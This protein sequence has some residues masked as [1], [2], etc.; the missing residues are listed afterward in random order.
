[1]IDTVKA[2]LWGAIGIRRRSAHDEAKI[3]PVH[4]AIL[5]VV[6]AVLFVL[7]LVTIVRIVTS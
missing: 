3:N 5:G 1:M 7:T 2:V 6:F 4:V